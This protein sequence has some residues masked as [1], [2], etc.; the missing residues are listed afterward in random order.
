METEKI[1][2][3]IVKTTKFATDIIEK[4]PTKEDTAFK[5]YVKCIAI[6]DSF[7]LK[8]FKDDGLKKAIIK[9]K[10]KRMNSQ[11]MKDLFFQTELKN[12]FNVTR[13]TVDDYA[14]LIKAE[15]GGAE[16]NFVEHNWGGTPW[17]SDE[18]FVKDEET[19][20]KVIEGMW[21]K[22]DGT[23]HVSYEFDP[24]ERK[25][26]IKLSTIEFNADPLLGKSDDKLNTVVAQ[27]QAFLKLGISRTYCLIGRPG[28]GKS[29]FAFRFANKICN[30]ILRFDSQ[31][32]GCVLNSIGPF[33]VSLKPQVIIFDD[34]DRIASLGEHM[35]TILTMMTE[36]KSKFP[37]VVIMLTANDEKKLGS[38]L[39]RPGRIDEIIDFEAPSKEDV[40]LL[41]VTYMD[42]IGAEYTDED[43]DRL[44]ELADGL[45]H[46]YIKELAIRK[47]VLPID[48]IC[49]GIERMKKIAGIQ[50]APEEE[51]KKKKKTTDIGE[52]A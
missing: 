14:T 36:I 50:A 46:S 31:E 20:D 9:L 39:L 12:E 8:F 41:L 45:A 23:I 33:I 48:D 6:A 3:Q 52:A 44:T 27:Q 37:E 24:I 1:I 47:K 30:R 51:K 5:K 7:R 4:L 43:L 15:S 38:A 26:T 17:V 42:S 34:F 18:F 22:Y 10:A 16:L 29:T 11:I 35:S 28:T 40:R 21:D 25:K 13:D 32:L 2:D 19:L 49:A